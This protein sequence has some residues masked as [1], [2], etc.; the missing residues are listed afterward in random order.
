MN[1]LFEIITI[2]NNQLATIKS[3]YR[4][5]YIDTY[6]NNKHQIKIELSEINVVLNVYSFFIMEESTT[7]GDDK[8]FIDVCYTEFIKNIVFSRATNNKLV[9]PVSN[10]IMMSFRDIINKS[11]N[12]E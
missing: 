7:N 1:K 5:N 3:N 10:K 12:N 6:N 8:L 4:L 11:T 9:N 2:I